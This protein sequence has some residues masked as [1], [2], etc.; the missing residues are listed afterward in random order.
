MNL[1]EIDWHYLRRGLTGS[2]SLLFVCGLLWGASTINRARLADE[3][4]TQRQAL[5]SLELERNDITNRREARRHF[6]ALYERLRAQGIVGGDQR[7]LWVQNARDAGDALK[8]PYLR[9]TTSPQQVFEAPW[10]VQGVSAPVTVSVMELQMGLVHE[11]DLMRLFARLRQSPGLFQVRS[12]ALERLGHNVTPA[13]DKA[14]VTGTC[15]L[16]WFSLPRETT[17]AAVNPEN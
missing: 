10:L 7:L 17:L 13:P 3:L 5:A 2:A 14:N 1:R 16:D 8:L 4:E 6:A 15:Q 9:Y 12:C 11:Q